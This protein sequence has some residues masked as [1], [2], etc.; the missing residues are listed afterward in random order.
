MTRDEAETVII[1]FASGLRLQQA[2]PKQLLPGVLE[3]AGKLWARCPD[4][5][6]LVR[7]DKPLFGSLHICLTDEE[8]AQK[9][10]A[11]RLRTE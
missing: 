7:L 5:A 2:A 3:M 9:R 1:E 10:V 4:C 11:D 8:K 6:K